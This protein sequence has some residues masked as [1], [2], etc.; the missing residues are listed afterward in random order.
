LYEIATMIQWHAGHRDR[1][2]AIL[3][4]G[5]A[6][7]RIGP[8]LARFL[9]V[10]RVRFELLAGQPE[11]AQAD[12]ERHRFDRL[13]WASTFQDEL[14]YRE[15]DLLGVCLCHLAI[16]QGNFARARQIVDRLEQIARLSGRTRTLVKAL[17]LRAAIAFHESNPA[18]AIPVLCDALELAQPMGYRR[19]F[20][21][22]AA[23][24][25]PILKA[26]ADR[27]DSAVLA[28]L[29]TYAQSLHEALS[30][31]GRSVPVDRGVA[32]SEREQDV[33][34]ELS[35]GHSNKLIARKL[36]LSAPTIKFHVNNI[37][38]KLGVRKRAAA[39]AEAH[40]RGCLS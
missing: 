15:W 9:P 3:A 38:R 1:I 8:M 33:L 28:H 7:Q 40:R 22:E 24:V 30:P 11:A 13:W 29:A 25:R 35:L 6:L 2:E 18:Q 39:V 37:F 36:G 12:I 5:A 21:D 34:R 20:L 32:L 26:I 4:R 17:T 27:A 31:K 10:L 16:V 23:L 19:V 14:T